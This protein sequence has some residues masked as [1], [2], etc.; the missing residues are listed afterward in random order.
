VFGCVT[1]TEHLQGPQMPDVCKDG[2][3]T[4]G[5]LLDW[6]R[7]DPLDRL[8]TFKSLRPGATMDTSYVHDAFDRV[9]TESEK[10]NGTPRTTSFTYLDLTDAVVSET[11]TGTAP[12]TK[13]YTYDAFE[14][15]VGMNV[16]EGGGVKR[17]FTFARNVHGDISLLLNDSGSARAAY[18]YTPY[19]ALDGDGTA[20]T[21][22]LSQGDASRDNPYN[23]Y[24]FNDRRYDS[25]SNTIDMGAR[26]FGPDVGRF[27]QQ[28]FYRGALDDL[29]L[30][31]DPLTQN[32]FGFA[33]GNPIS[34]VE[35]DGHRFDPGRPGSINVI[36][37][38]PGFGE[39]PAEAT[40]D[41]ELFLGV[42]S[43]GSLAKNVL[44]RSFGG[45]KKLFGWGKSKP[46]SAL[47]R[48]PRTRLEAFALVAGR[49]NP[50]KAVSILARDV[51]QQGLAHLKRRWMTPA[52]RRRW[53][54]TPRL[55]GAI[56]GA[57]MHRAVTSKLN[58]LFPGRF[59]A[60]RQTIRGARLRPDWLDT[61]TGRI[62]DLTTLGEVPR[63]IRRYAPWVIRNRITVDLVV[64][65]R[66]R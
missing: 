47:A 56:E 55:R 2:V 50:S 60:N 51:E 4:S 31:I 53:N 37:L 52:M 40:D 26:R 16:D 27:L 48:A 42:V 59:V 24:R 66:P 25:G 9:S 33:A 3:D 32:R 28:D 61:R 36:V 49:F 29:D 41:L 58:R 35:T 46:K 64:Y 5:D 62:I 22:G 57:A 11:Q 45:L 34:F 54:Q 43:I 21:R 44:K 63:H 65:R 30:S 10:F 6:Y 38:P 13:S 8:K 7:L 12:R 15:R 1:R 14:E 17:D 39:E 23:P 19:G 18:G 20:S